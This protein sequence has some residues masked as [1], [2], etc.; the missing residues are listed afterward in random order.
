MYSFIYIYNPVSIH[1]V[2]LIYGI[3]FISIVYYFKSYKEFNNF[4]LN[5]SIFLF[6]CTIILIIFYLFVLYLFGG[7]GALKR[8]YSLI[9][10]ILSFI[11]AAGIALFFKRYI[12]NKMEDL[13]SFF[14]GLS[15]FQL[16]FVFLS[17]ALP[18][19]RNWSL[20]FASKDTFILSN[21]LDAGL[22]SY[23]FAS[24]YT[25]SFPMMMGLVSLFCIFLSMKTKKMFHRIFYILMFIFLIFSISINARIG[26]LPSLLSL[27]C[28]PLILIRKLDIK[29]LVI[30]ILVFYLIYLFFLDSILNLAYIERLIQGYNEIEQLLT[31][32]ELIGTFSTLRD[33]WILPQDRIGLY[34]GEGENTLGGN[35]YQSD[36]GLVQDIFMYGIVFTILLYSGLLTLLVPLL[37][38]FKRYFGLSF[39]LIFLFSIFCF[40]MKGTIFGSNELFRMLFILVIFSYT[41]RNKKIYS[42]REK[43][44]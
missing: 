44:E 20:N 1:G 3:Y 9:L 19:F 13:I 41:I 23:G 8:A 4:F 35:L 14:I 39:L 6:L 34:F 24:G 42:L 31:N 28:I 33:M 12:S 7:D 30:L 11:S 22:R 43:V 37:V 32:R 2:G 17:I 27:F 21:D 16:F 38:F 5:K 15:L 29:I 18:E 36:I 25:S 10:V 26:L 40:Y